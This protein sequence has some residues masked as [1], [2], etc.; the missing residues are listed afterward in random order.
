MK[1]LKSFIVPLTGFILTLS[2]MMWFQSAVRAQEAPPAPGKPAT[3]LNN[4]SLTGWTNA[5]L[6]GAHIY[7]AA[8]DPLHDVIFLSV[9]GGTYK[10]SN[11][12]AS[13][14]L[15][16]QDGVHGLAVDPVNGTVYIGVVTFAP[17][18]DTHQ[19]WTS[20]DG[21]ENWVSHDV[22]GALPFSIGLDPNNGQVAFVGTNSF[23]HPQGGKVFRTLNGGDTWQG[24]SVDPG[25]CISS[26]AVDPL[27]ANRV[28]AVSGACDGYPNH[29]AVYLS[30]DRGLTYNQQYYA[31]N[32]YEYTQVAF[33][34]AGTLFLM[35]DGLR[36]SDDGGLTFSA[37]DGR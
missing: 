34:K 6:Y 16:T 12:G 26:V 22:L 11:A 15:I 2:L 20:E 18:P 33:D 32:G 29:S 9:A 13:W 19:I 8:F 37:R 27:N 21:G 31:S 30:T 17:G 14:T 35:G 25:Y 10:S 28:W 1:T 4:D 7:T 36:H 3:L 5:G 24:V 23:D